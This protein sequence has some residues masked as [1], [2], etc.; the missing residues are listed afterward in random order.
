MSKIILIQPKKIK[1]G[2]FSEIRIDNKEKK[3]INLFGWQIGWLGTYIIFSLIFS[4]IMRKLL[5]VH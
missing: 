5:K 1:N 4:L 2:G 3:V